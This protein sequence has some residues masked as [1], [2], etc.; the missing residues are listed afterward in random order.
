MRFM[1]IMWTVWSVLV[2]IMASLFVYRSRLTKNEEDQI[3]LDDSFEQERI[4]QA[5]IVAKATKIEPILRI[6]EWVVLVMSLVVVLY[7][8]RDILIH[9]ELIH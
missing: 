9:L 5:A 1:P 2:A 6:S 8:I 7:Y 3:F 4:E